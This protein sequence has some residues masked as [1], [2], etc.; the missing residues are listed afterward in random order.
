[1]SAPTVDIT[2][3]DGNTN[4]TAEN[5][6]KLEDEARLSGQ[7]MFRLAERYLDENPSLKKVV[8][9]EHPPRFDLPDV[10]PH[11]VKPN[12]AKLANIHLGQL[13][14]NSSMKEKI[15]IG[16]HS[17]ESPG[18]G[19]AHFRR[20]QS[21]F[22]GRYDGVHLYGLTAHTD[23]TNSVKTILSLALP[24][25]QPNYLAPKFVKTKVKVDDHTN[26][27]QALYQRHQSVQV[28]NRF[29]VLKL[30]GGDISQ[31]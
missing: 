4:Q 3:L 31:L 19:A 26:C 21:S 12:L 7:N 17:L 6:N 5:K 29:D 10:D 28:K 20:Y 22:T 27:P 18:A 9:M 14:L 30:L 8:I 25:S 2:N 16:R 11:S 13:W 23:Y 1:M 24:I 15:F